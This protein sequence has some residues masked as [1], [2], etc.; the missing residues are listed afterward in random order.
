MDYFRALAR[1]PRRRL[2]SP[3]RIPS[4]ELLSDSCADDFQLHVDIAAGGVRIGTDLL[5]RLGRQRRQVGLRKTLVLDV[6][7]DCKAEPTGF[8][9]T[10]RHRAG[11]PRLRCILAMLL[12]DEVE[13]AAE[14]SR[15]TGGEQMLRRRGAGLA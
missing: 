14:A 8:A 6:Q 11:D 12:A 7:L 5:V 9:R 3:A 13:G 1:V 15:V 2:A 4:A 10:D